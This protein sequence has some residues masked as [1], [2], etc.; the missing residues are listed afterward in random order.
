MPFEEPHHDSH[1]FHLRFNF[2]EDKRLVFIQFI[3]F[4]IVSSLL[5]RA[6]GNKYISL[7]STEVRATEANLFMVIQNLY[8]CRFFVSIR[9][10]SPQVFL[11]CTFN[12][13]SLLYRYRR[14]KCRPDEI[15]PSPIGG[16]SAA[17]V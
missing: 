12:T 6:S 4:L 13:L 17:A 3:P 5:P 11:S 8:R 14:I 15:R 10:S 7:A 1:I 9:S 16:A 2:R